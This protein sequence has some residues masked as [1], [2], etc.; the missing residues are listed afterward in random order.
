[1]R[2]VLGKAEVEDAL[3][4]LDLLTK[5]DNLTMM[6]ARNLED[7]YHFDDNATVVEEIFQDAHDNVRATQE[8]FCDVGS[9]TTNLGVIDN[10]KA[11]QLGMPHPFNFFIY[12]LILLCHVH[13]Q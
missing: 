12:V 8:D 7:A 5:E 1:M 2:K 6:M 3:Q 9:H 13:Q 4:R 10:F 11:T